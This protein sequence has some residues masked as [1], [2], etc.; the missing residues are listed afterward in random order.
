MPRRKKTKKAWIKPI[1][2]IVLR[3]ETGERLLAVCKMPGFVEPSG[4]GSLYYGC[5]SSLTCWPCSVV[6]DS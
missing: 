2:S 6:L 4:P 1:L 3:G 5:Q